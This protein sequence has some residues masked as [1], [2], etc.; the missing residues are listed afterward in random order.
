MIL[1][2]ESWRRANEI[3]IDKYWSGEIA[4]DGRHFKAKLLWSDSALYVRFCANQANFNRLRSAE[5][6]DKNNR[7]LGQRRVRDF[8]RAA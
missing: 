6:A 5:S 8:R 1:K 4:P 2:T 7:A 3:E